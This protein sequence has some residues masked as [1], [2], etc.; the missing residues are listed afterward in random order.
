MVNGED[1]Q[2]IADAVLNILKSPDMQAALSGRAREH[3]LQNFT[4]DRRKDALKNLISD[5]S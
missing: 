3:I 1:P 4:Y 2:A 5:L